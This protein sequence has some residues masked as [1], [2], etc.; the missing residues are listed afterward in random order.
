MEWLHGPIDI[1]WVRVGRTTDWFELAW[2]AV[3][4]V[5]LL[6]ASYNLWD[7][8]RYLHA[9][10]SPGVSVGARLLAPKDLRAAYYGVGKAVIGLLIGTPLLFTPTGN[11]NGRA[12]IILTSILLRLG[13]IGIG[14]LIAATATN[15]FLFRRK[16]KNLSPRSR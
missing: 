9:S 8:R 2:I 10:R 11:Y 13:F 15:D 16:I 14:A 5:T 4:C 12:D 1:S 6:C 3:F 7:A